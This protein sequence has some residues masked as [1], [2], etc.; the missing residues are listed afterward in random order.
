[1]SRYIIK[2]GVLTQELQ[3]HNPPQMQD[4]MSW[5]EFEAVAKALGQEPKK[6]KEEKL[7]PTDSAPRVAHTLVLEGVLFYNY[8][9]GKG[10]QSIRSTTGITGRKAILFFEQETDQSWAVA[11]TENL[12]K[13]WPGLG[14]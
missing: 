5:D 12:K 11:L 14:I 4:P 1:M 2:D 7:Y 9:G 13:K 8:Y 3:K 6:I 10:E